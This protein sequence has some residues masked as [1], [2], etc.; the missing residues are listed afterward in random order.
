[1]SVST[2]VLDATSGRPASGVAVSLSRRDGSSWVSVSS[3]STDA[4]G[5]IAELAPDTP[6]GVYRLHFDTGAYLGAT[7]FYPEVVVTFRVIEAGTNHHVPL[8][9]SP[10]AYS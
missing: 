9:L 7:A 8:L 10:Y 5:R 6:E 3:G 1:M 4:D 2:H